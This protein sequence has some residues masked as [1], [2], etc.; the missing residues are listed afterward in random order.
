M[1]ESLTFYLFAAIVTTLSIAVI[2]VKNPVTAVALL[3][4]N[5]FFL[6]GV[7]ALLGADFVA[8]IQV[9]VYAGAI[10]V[11]FMFVIMLLNPDIK[12][13][14]SREIKKSSLLILSIILLSFTF[15]GYKLFLVSSSPANPFEKTNLDNTYELGIKLFSKYLWPFEIA[16]LLILLAIVA[17]IIITQKPSTI[18][19][20]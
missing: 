12:S 14:S 9:I 20:A 3:V 11:L 15:L 18:N 4:F 16:S 6:A 1:G 8:V 2:T 13:Q 7:Y 5:L 17:S 10:L 19:K